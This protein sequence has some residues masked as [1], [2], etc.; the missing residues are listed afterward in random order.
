MGSQNL[1]LTMVGIVI[2]A[3]AISVAVSMFQSNSIDSNRKAIIGD[4]QFFASK[5]RS[6]YVRPA[7]AAGG[8]RSFVG[9]TITRLTTR[10]QNENGRYFIESATADELVLVGK[11]KT[12]DDGDTVEVRM[13]MR[14]EKIQAMEVIH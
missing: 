3:L 12:V 1:I 2:V 13:R 7:S 10:T 6:Y 4:L 14:N 9:L 8:N 5:A 11:G